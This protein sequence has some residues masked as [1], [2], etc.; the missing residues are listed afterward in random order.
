VAP[1][2]GAAPALNA[3]LSS[4]MPDGY[5]PTS[6]ALSGALDQARAL[7]ASSN[8]RRAAV[9]LA[10]D[11]LPT[12]CA[13]KDIGGVAA[14]AQK[15]FAGTPSIPTFVIGVFAPEEQGAIGNLN[16]LASSGGTGSAR[17]VDANRNV[18]Q[19][20]LKALDDIRATAVACEFKVPAMTAQ[21]KVDFGNVNVR[22]TGG[23]GTE[24][25]I[26][27]AGDRSRCK[28]G[29]Q[30]WFYDVDPAMG[31]PTKILTC[32]A[33]CNLLRSDPKGRIDILIGCKTVVIP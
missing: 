18:T 25:N 7:A 11:G 32:D 19:A 28:P 30:G 20:F 13:P 17:V 23:S 15:A 2:P 24:V 33:T 10:T 16:Q 29:E 4:R 8:D 22:F 9:V 5:T 12:A 6:A 27:Y 1:L 21:G 14:L 26:G 3:A 31:T